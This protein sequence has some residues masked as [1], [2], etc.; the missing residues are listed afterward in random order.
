M[1]AA[2]KIEKSKIYKKKKNNHLSAVYAKYSKSREMNN[3][4]CYRQSFL[5]TLRVRQALIIKEQDGSGHM[6]EAKC[7]WSQLLRGTFHLINKGK[8]ENFIF[9]TQLLGELVFLEE[10]LK[11]S[12]GLSWAGV[13]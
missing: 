12:L 10:T 6:F 8:E 2:V 1:S 13:K 4:L 7:D 5:D 9:S 11:Q 3:K